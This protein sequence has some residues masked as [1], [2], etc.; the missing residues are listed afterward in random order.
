M[1]VEIKEVNIDLEKPLLTY[2]SASLIFYNNE[3]N[4]LLCKEKRDNK[5]LYHPIGGKYETKDANIGETAIRE[6]VE[7]TMI[8]KIAEF[9]NLLPKNKYQVHISPER[10][11]DYLIKDSIEYLYEKIFN[12]ESIEYRDYIVNQY[13]NYV[14]RFYILCVD[15]MDEKIRNIIINLD[16]Y[17]EEMKCGKIEKLEWNNEFME[18]DK[19][20]VEEYSRLSIYLHICLYKKKNKKSKKE[21]VKEKVDKENI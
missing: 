5:L 13:M 10:Q 2:K 21:Y 8:Y 19:L 17:Y 12:E 3:K 1:S 4:Y 20:N 11:M 16:K 6:F 18:K 9:Q 14:H 7:E 15:K